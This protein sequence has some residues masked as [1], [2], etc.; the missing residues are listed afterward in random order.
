MNCV[1]VIQFYKKR[2]SFFYFSFT[3]DILRSPL[4]C[5][6]PYTRRRMI[7]A[8]Y[9]FILVIFMG[10]FL[11]YN[12]AVA[13]GPSKGLER[14][15]TFQIGI[16]LMMVSILFGILIPIQLKI[17]FERT[18]YFSFFTIFLIP[19]IVPAII[20][21]FQSQGINLQ[22]ELV[23]MLP[24]YVREWLPIG[25]SFVIGIISMKISIRIFTAKNL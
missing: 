13:I 2:P 14:L 17:G 7:E 3:Q 1:V 16:S 22:M 21:G 20:E 11:L 19:F 9:L 25:V 15:T 23:Q 6:T 4:L 5:T 8:K 12:L 10:T 24:I 18:K